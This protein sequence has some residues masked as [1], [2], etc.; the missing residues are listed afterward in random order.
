MNNF[1]ATYF[2]DKS[3]KPPRE[4]HICADC[5]RSA[6]TQAESRS[7]LGATRYEVSARTVIASGSL[8][9]KLGEGK[10]KTISFPQNQSQRQS[11]S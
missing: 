8:S 6:R 3:G 9:G 11:G 10:C 5:P 2:F 7:P 1:T 4:K